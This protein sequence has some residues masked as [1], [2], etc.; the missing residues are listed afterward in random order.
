M[1]VNADVSY[2]GNHN[3]SELMNQSKPGSHDSNNNAILVFLL[4]TSSFFHLLTKQKPD[5]KSKIIY[6]TSNFFFSWK[7]R[8]TCSTCHTL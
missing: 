8:K 3:L 1:E 5:V 7:L 6:P 2:D 4:L